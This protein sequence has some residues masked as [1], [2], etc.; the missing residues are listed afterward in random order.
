MAGQ[1]LIGLLPSFPEGVEGSG[2]GD[3]LTEVEA[4]LL[5]LMLAHFV[6]PVCDMLLFTPS[7]GVSVRD[8][9]GI[10]LPVAVL[11]SKDSYFDGRLGGVCLIPP[12]VGGG[13]L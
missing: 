11:P 3:D 10:A 6:S 12:V 8:G 1:K 5:G 9:T 7:S 4:G 13:D 2:R